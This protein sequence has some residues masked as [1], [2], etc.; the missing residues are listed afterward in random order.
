VQVGYG[1]TGDTF[2]AFEAEGVV[3]DIVCV[4]KAVGNGHPV[5]A[6]MCRREIAD[7]FA[8][9]AP[10]FSSTGGGPVSCRIGVAVLDAIEQER[11]QENAR[12]VGARL[13][14]GFERLA[15]AHPLIGA[16]HGRGLYL[17]VDLVRDRESKEPAA[18]EAMAICERMRALGV[19][20]QPTGDAS[21][22]LKVK[23]P[24]CIDDAGADHLLAALGQTLRDGW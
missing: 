14:S 17:G 19:I 9:T 1:R 3:P 20:V 2:W 21:N 8:A 22:V 13:R 10:F 24:L 7:A 18:A 6:V 23:P 16:V 12:R 15:A 5:G 4:A 11:L